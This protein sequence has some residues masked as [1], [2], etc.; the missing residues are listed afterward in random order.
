M[1]APGAVTLLPVAG[2]PKVQPGDDLAALIR[3]R[4]E[5]EPGDIVVV[6]SKIVSKSEGCI[7]E[8]GD[9]EP[10]ARAHELAEVTGKDPRLIEL[11]LRESTEVVRAVFGVLL[12][13]HRL[14]FTSANGAIDASNVG[15]GDE[16]VLVLP[17]DPDASA[18][19]LRDGL[20]DGIGV[21]IAD[22]HGRAFRRGNVGV[23]IG[24]AGVIGL[25]DQR[26]HVDL[27]GRVLEATV[28]PT[29]DL[30]AA[31]AGLVTGEAAEG[32]PV[33]VVRGSGATSSVPA[34]ASDLLRLPE[35]DLFAGRR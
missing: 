29:A 5:L 22:T 2:M 15:L 20:G 24:I 23:A 34:A 25:D 7:V 4:V 1:A 14:G 19:R 33:V 10:S 26:G 11:I 28:V 35:E 12:V 9:L 27:F 8:L 13:R 30:L 17:P 21:V 31:A 6:A 3:E 32:I 16:T 18:A